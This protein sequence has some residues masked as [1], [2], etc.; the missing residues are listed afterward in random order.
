MFCSEMA[1]PV[2]YHRSGRF[3]EL[4]ACVTEDL[5][6]IFQT[7]HTV[8]TLTSSGTGGMEAALASSLCPGPKSSVCIAGR[9]GERWRRHQLSHWVP[10]YGE[11]D[12]TVPGEKLR[13]AARPNWRMR[14]ARGPTPVAVCATLCEAATG[15]KNDIEAHGSIAGA[16]IGR[17]CSTWSMQSSSLGAMPCLTDEWGVDVCV[18]GSQKGLMLPPGLAFVSVSEKGWRVMGARR[19]PAAASLL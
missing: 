17:Y 9:W 1:Q 11:L 3:R 4:L 19:Q 7:R 13:V 5:Q 18:T 16:D 2:F 12:R 14:Y 10:R 8:L 15:V 6:Y